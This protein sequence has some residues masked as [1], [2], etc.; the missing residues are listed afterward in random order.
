MQAAATQRFDMKNT[1]LVTGAS[2]G[3]GACYADRLARRG[4][5]LVLVA[6]DAKRLRAVADRLRAAAGVTVDVLPADLTDPAQTRAVEN[7]LRDDASIRVLINNAGSATPAG[8]LASD[9]EPQYK[10]VDL[11]V[12]ALTRLAGAAVQGFLAH[13]AEGAIVNIGSV[14]GFA[15]EWFPGVYGATKAYV[16]ALSTGLRAELASRSIYIQ[17]VLPA[18]TKTEIWERSGRAIRDDMMEVGALVDAA[19]VGFDK[20]EAVTIPPLHKGEL[21]DAWEATRTGLFPHLNNTVP[22][23]RYL[24]AQAAKEPA[25]VGIV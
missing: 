17:T 6:R 25:H 11:N 24:G 21:Y 15:P 19:L 18:G 12:G 4:H 16:L 9:L 1:A 14:V 2:S 8:F 10:L 23:D 22:A 20:R 13:D 7:R 3:I 5:D